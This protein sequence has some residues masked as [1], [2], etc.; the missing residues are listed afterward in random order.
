MPSQ[1]LEH[2]LIQSTLISALDYV[3][4]KHPA[5]PHPKKAD[6]RR[7]LRKKRDN[8]RELAEVI[9]EPPDEQAPI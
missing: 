7:R 1:M 9:V 4:Q 3:I 8:P 5:N 6:K 2:H